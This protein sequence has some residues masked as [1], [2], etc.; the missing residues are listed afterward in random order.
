MSFRGCAGKGWT[1]SAKPV[2]FDRRVL[3]IVNFLV[4][5]QKI[6]S[7]S[8]VN[9]KDLLMHPIIVALNVVNRGK[10]ELSNRSNL[11]TAICRKIS[12]W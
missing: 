8:L 6:R 4:E 1:G 3:K 5:R 9:P 7:L 11:F 2:D 10:Q 12:W